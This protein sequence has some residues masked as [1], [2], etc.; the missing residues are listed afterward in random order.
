MRTFVLN[1]DFCCI[2]CNI[3][4][5]GDAGQVA[6]LFSA[7]YMWH[8]LGVK[9]VLFAKWH[10]T[11]TV[12]HIVSCIMLK[13]F[14]IYCVWLSYKLKGFWQV[15][16]LSNPTFLPTVYSPALICFGRERGW[17]ITFNYP[18]VLKEKNIEKQKE[19]GLRNLLAKVRTTWGKA[20]DMLRQRANKRNEKL[21][22]MSSDIGAEQ[23]NHTVGRGPT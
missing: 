1:K 3:V 14:L 22:R 20:S 19:Y 2:W 18:T 12:Q 16:T 11:H 9:Q 6:T 7:V 21:C 23:E 13:Y 5:W 10:W 15:L 17:W 4:E 8:F